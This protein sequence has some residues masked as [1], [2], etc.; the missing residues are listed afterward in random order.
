M[1]KSLLSGVLVALT[2]TAI[3]KSETSTMQRIC[4]HS[5]TSEVTQDLKCKDCSSVACIVSN[6][7]NSTEILFAPE[8]FELEET[9]HIEDREGITLSG[10]PTLQTSIICTTIDETKS[11]EGVGLRFSNVRN[12]SLTNITLSGCGIVTRVFPIR[13]AL[14]FSCCTHVKISAVTVQE[15]LGSGLTFINTNGEVLVEDSTFQ[16]NGLTIE[17]LV[18]S[19]HVGGVYIYFNV[20]LNY[21]DR[22]QQYVSD[23]TYDFTVCYFLNNSANVKGKILDSHTI[24]IGRGGGMGIVLSSTAARNTITLTRCRFFDNIALWGAGMHVQFINSAQQN[25]LILQDCH[26]ENNRSP[27][28]GGGAM[29]IIH[30][31][32]SLEWNEVIAENTRFFHNSAQFG[33]GI[34]LYTKPN[35]ETNNYSQVFTFRNC[36][37][38]DNEAMFGSAM[39]VFSTPSNSFP[40]GFEIKILFIDCGFINNIVVHKYMNTSE[41]QYREGKGALTVTAHSIQLEG[42]SEFYGN[43]G[44]AV[45]MVMSTAT[46]SP[47]STVTFENN[48]GFQ[49]GAI[50]LIGMSAIVAQDNSTVIFR[51]NSARVGGGAIYYYSVD[52]HEVF[53]GSPVCFIR[54]LHKRNRNIS[55]IFEGNKAKRNNGVDIRASTIKPCFIM[56]DVSFKTRDP[57]EVF[58]CIGDFKFTKKVGSVSTLGRFYTLSKPEPLDI[59]PGKEF[60]IPFVLKDYFDDR[61]NEYYNVEVT[62]KNI[63]VDPA[64]TFIVNQSMKVYGEP[65]ETTDLVLSVIGRHPIILVVKINLIDCPPGFYITKSSKNI[66]CT[67]SANTK[68]F[69]EGITYCDIHKYYASIRRALWVGYE[70]KGNNISKLY[71]ARCPPGYCFQWHN[72]SRSSEHIFHDLPGE[73]SRKG[74]DRA[75]CGSS[76]TGIVCGKCRFDRSVYY[77]TYNL[78]CGNN[79]KCEMGWIFYVLSELLPLTVFFLVVMYFDISFTS[80]AAS[81]LIFFAQ[82]TDSLSISGQASIWLEKPVYIL[83]KAY[84]FI[85]RFF[86]FEYFSNNN[87]AFCLIK[88]ATALDMLAFKY[89]TVI[90]ALMLIFVIVFLLN[91]CSVYFY[92]RHSRLTKHTVRK[93]YIHGLSAFLIMCYTQCIRVSFLLLLPTALW[94]KGGKVER[95]VVFWNGELNYMSKEHL[96]YALPAIACL[97]TAIIFPALLIIYPLHY[98]VIAIL[99]LDDKQWFL[100][101]SKYISLEKFKPLLDSF[102]SCFKDNC[103]FFSG[104]FFLYRFVLLLTF[105]VSRSYTRFYAFVEIQLIIILAVHA[106]VKPYQKQMHNIIDT[107][108]FTNLALI[109]TI[110]LLNYALISKR[111]EQNK[112]NSILSSI[113]LILVYLPLL[114]LFGYTG[115]RTFIKIKTLLKRENQKADKEEMEELEMPARLIHGDEMSD[116]E[117]SSDYHNYDGNLS[118]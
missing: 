80:G 57:A 30:R 95:T 115:W 66:M 36:I 24:R 19:V 65:G 7:S 67:C 103:R 117:E 4:V 46:L 68:Y 76:R 18:E 107:L 60:L 83:T 110:T 116:T 11:G 10:N 82:V 104:L 54:K 34:A 91:Y 77:H 50:A 9:L 70:E 8:V 52:Q 38:R 71:T 99:Q 62:N 84:R 85:Y 101:I 20:S 75:V 41:S 109:N 105:T 114:T 113:Q 42:S 48:S 106:Y 102:Q 45:Y 59:I 31:S 87:F 111:G 16:K 72:N 73:A 88:G 33:G 92:K 86:N 94:T 97:I 44:T 74:L 1:E 61:T 3:V 81:G 13:S 22:N 21:C 25:R 27:T 28:L 29:N 63:L 108:V 53:K 49:G 43:N 39:D 79:T 2:V 6:V 17:S 64:Y 98:R 14:F 15:S 78:F 69:Y 51:N 5:Q 112:I 47:Y 90:Y 26:F 96:A 100:R 40:Y 58:K 89:V 118:D 55:F 35:M 56:C 32:Q 93:S 23:A 12:I 37:W